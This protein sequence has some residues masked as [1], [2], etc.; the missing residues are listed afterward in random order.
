MIDYRSQHYFGNVDDSG[1][2]ITAQNE[3][4]QDDSASSISYTHIAN[5]LSLDS[6]DASSRIV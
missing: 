5:R 4:G 6:S 2:I 1:G 3:S